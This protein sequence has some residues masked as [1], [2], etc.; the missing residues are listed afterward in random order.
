[1]DYAESV[2]EKTLEVARKSYDELHE[3]VYKLA[4]VLAAGAGAIGA[5]ALGK[6]GE[7][8]A[9]IQWASLGGLS[10][11]WFAIAGVLM[12]R[13]ATSRLVSP[14]NGPDNIRKYFEARLAEQPEGDAGRDDAAMT[15]TRQAEL[16]LKQKRLKGYI[17]GCDAR[18]NAVDLAYMSVAFS[19]LVPLAVIA[20]L[21]AL[22]LIK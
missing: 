10:I 6:I 21:F 8:A 18:S 11:S 19:P 12:V 4:T 13:G 7:P 16:D 20:L 22:G 15:I 1:L 2:S 3:R 17:D 5:Y 9:V 14:G